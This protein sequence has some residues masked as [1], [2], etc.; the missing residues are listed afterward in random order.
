MGDRTYTS[1][2][3][4]GVI[5]E[6]NVDELLDACNTD[7]VTCD[8]GPSLLHGLQPDHL[9]YCLYDL[10]A[11]YGE[12]RAIEA[13]CKDLGVSYCKSWCEGGGYSSGM[14]IYNAVVGVTMQCGTIDGE[15]AVTLSDLEKAGSPEDLVGYLKAF[16]NFVDNYGE[17][18][19]KP[20]S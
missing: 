18:E 11:N 10:E 1:I 9:K 6:E 16:N 20:C 17:L 4:A 2:L 12:L 3:F 8:D 13:T 7:G 14:E 5:N 15:P 19:I